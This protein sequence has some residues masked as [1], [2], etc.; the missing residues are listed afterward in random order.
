ME[1]GSW[2]EGF[3]GVMSNVVITEAGQGTGEMKKWTY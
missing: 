1:V 3:K 2:G